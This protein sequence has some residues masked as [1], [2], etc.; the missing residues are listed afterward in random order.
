MKILRTLV[1]L[2]CAMALAY[3]SGWPLHGDGLALPAGMAG[4][5]SLL[6]AVFP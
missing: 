3:L 1:L 4:A 2:V 5:G 6:L